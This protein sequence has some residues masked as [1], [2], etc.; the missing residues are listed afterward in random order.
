MLFVCYLEGILFQA[1]LEH[2]RAAMLRPSIISA[3]LIN[4]SGPEHLARQKQF[5]KKCHWSSKFHALCACHDIGAVVYD[6][7]DVCLSKK[8]FSIWSMAYG[9][10]TP[11]NVNF[12]SVNTICT[13]NNYTV[14]SHLMHN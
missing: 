11:L 10:K 3:C 9:N 1:G 2:V 13:S 7:L 4:E 6:V 14:Y 8:L 12:S 5:H